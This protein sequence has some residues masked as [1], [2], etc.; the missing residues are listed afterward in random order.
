[1]WLS[2]RRH[3]L[4]P[5]RARLSP[6]LPPASE[7]FSLPPGGSSPRLESSNPRILES[8]SFRVQGVM[9]TSHR[10]TAVVITAIVHAY[11]SV[12][13]VHVEN[14]ST[15]AGQYV[16]E[17]SEVSGRH[18][19]SRRGIPDPAS[20]PSYPAR[21]HCFAKV[22]AGRTA[23]RSESRKEGTKQRQGAAD[24]TGPAPDAGTEPSVQE[25]SGT[26][27]SA[28]EYSEYNSSQCPDEFIDSDDEEDELD[29]TL[30]A[31]QLG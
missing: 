12:D 20:P 13:A 16:R 18:L 29:E 9:H 2:P 27:A 28:Q 6:G 1:M 26:A 21:E 24:P 19:G 22:C 4:A 5:P 11:N 25:C 14:G 8:F 3:G 17:D 23:L 15:K 31:L 10:L 30:S 7:V